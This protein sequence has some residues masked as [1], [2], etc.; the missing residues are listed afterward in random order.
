[1][2]TLP[3]SYTDNIENY[4]IETYYKYTNISKLSLHIDKDFLSKRKFCIK[5][6]TQNY[7]KSWQSQPMAQIK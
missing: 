5:W 1:M 4:V 7:L 6:A 3:I 2:I